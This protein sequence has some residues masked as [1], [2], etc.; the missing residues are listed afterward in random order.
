MILGETFGF[1][2]FDFRLVKNK[3][4]KMV[5][6]KPKKKKVAE[7]ISKV[8]IHLSQN[9]DKVVTEMI[10]QLNPIL[11]GWVNYYRIGHCSRTLT[12]IK[13]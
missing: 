9:R 10:E 2:G 6:L 12:I 8:K 1:L 7:L 13:I 5:L 11:R 3:E 4:K